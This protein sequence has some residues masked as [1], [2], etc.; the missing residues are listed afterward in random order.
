MAIEVGQPAPP[1]TLLNRDREKVTLES[2]PE[3]H[4]V[5]AFYPLA[6]TGGCTSEMQAYRDEL[7]LFEEIGAQVLGISVDSFAAAGEFQDKLTTGFPLLSDFPSNQTGIDYGAYD[8]KFGFHDR[9]TVIIDKDRIIRGI[10]RER[11][12]Y[13]SHPGAALEVLKS[14]DA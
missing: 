12:D 10:Y 14:L 1:F 11:K 13:A 7:Y 4:M 8:E 6:F 5:L 2:Y 9:M 3:Q